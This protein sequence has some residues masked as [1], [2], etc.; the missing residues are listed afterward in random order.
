MS[1]QI[2]MTIADVV[3]NYIEKNKGNN[4]S[5]FIEELIRIGIEQHQKEIKKEVK[6]DA[7]QE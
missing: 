5:E 3:Y 7:K 6:T 4:R 2:H 1:Q